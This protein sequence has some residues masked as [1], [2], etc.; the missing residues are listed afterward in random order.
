[1]EKDTQGS[2]SDDDVLNFLEIAN[3][4]KTRKQKLSETTSNNGDSQEFIHK[5]PKRQKLD[6]GTSSSSRT[7]KKRK[8]LCNL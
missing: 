4:S 1:M 7:Q 8:L 3:I 5:K 2:N 6:I